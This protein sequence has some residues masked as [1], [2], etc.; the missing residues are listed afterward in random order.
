MLRSTLMA[1]VVAALAGSSQAE[2]IVTAGDS[3]VT[4][5]MPG[6]RTYTLTATTDDG[7]LIQGFDFASRPEYGIFGQMNHVNPADRPTIFQHNNGLFPF[8]GAVPAQD[9]QFMFPAITLTIPAGFASESNTRL[10][11][12]FASAAPIGQSVPFAQL[13]VPTVDNILISP[14]GGLNFRGQIQTV[15]SGGGPPRD[16]DVSGSFFGFGS[17]PPQFTDIHIDNLNVIKPGSVS[18]TLSI[19]PY[20]YISDFRFDSYVPEAGASGSGPAIPATLDFSHSEYNWTFNWNAAG[21]P[22]GTYKWLV[23]ATNAYG[24]D[25][26]SI[27]VRITPEPASFS[28]LGLALMACGRIMRRR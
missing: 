10:R 14:G 22:L 16:N 12:V 25:D 13:V 27:T 9:S 8:V 18:R 4:P 11:A 1:L 5:N 2:V 7:S 20:G 19:L 21:S 24:V 28:L 15:P 17:P 6:F 23:T 26:G 3:V